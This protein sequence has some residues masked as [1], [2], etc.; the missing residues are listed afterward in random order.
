VDIAFL[1]WVL[2][3]EELLVG[4]EQQLGLGLKNMLE[5]GSTKP[6]GINEQL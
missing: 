4:V 6:T 1:V 2:V 3:V 5:E